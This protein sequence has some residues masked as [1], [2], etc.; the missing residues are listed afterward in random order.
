[1]LISELV[2]AYNEGLI[3]DKQIENGLTGEYIPIVKGQRLN[4]FEI[5]MLDNEVQKQKSGDN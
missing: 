1:M 4:M 2:S 3:T 5:A